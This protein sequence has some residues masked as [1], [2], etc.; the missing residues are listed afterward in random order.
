MRCHGLHTFCFTIQCVSSICHSAN[1]QRMKNKPDHQICVFLLP[2]AMTPSCADCPCALP[3]RR[4]VQP[5]GG[6]PRAGKEAHAGAVQ[7]RQGQQRGEVRGGWGGRVGL[8]GWQGGWSSRLM[9]GW[10]GG[11]MAE[12]MAG[13]PGWPTPPSSHSS[14]RRHTVPRS[15]SQ[16][17][18]V[19]ADGRG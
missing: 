15:K 17:C 5:L 12:W 7:R 19:E 11:W 18:R 10:V 3:A 9:A 1:K 4:L 2:S 16:Y 6:R 13:E 14:S 8:V